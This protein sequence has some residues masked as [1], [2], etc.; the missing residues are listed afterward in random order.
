MKTNKSIIGFFKSKC[1][2]NEISSLVQKRGI[3]FLSSDKIEDFSEKI[4]QKSLLIIDI[5]SK[6][7]ILKLFEKGSEISDIAY[8]YKFTNSNII[9]QLKKLCFF[10]LISHNNS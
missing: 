6:K 1:I 4:E 2:I 10:F 3:S 8:K 9:R 5:S 7:E